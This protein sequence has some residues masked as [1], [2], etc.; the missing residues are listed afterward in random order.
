MK[1]E[2]TLEE[3]IEYIYLTLRKQERREKFRVTF[4]W[5]FRICIIAYLYYFITIGLPALIESYI[6]N[7]P[8]L[9]VLQEL[10]QSWGALEWINTEKIQETLEQLQWIDSS[11]LKDLKEKYLS[12]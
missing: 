3:K 4:K 6:P 1:E 5:L 2:L 11:T 8:D 9:S 10:Q 12:Q 7:L